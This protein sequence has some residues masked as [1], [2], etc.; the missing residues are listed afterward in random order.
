MIDLSIRPEPLQ[1]AVERAR[2]R[3]IVIP[4]FVQ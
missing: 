4:T 1:R 3:D 2:E